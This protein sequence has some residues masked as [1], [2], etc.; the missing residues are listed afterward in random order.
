[1][2]PGLFDIDDC[3]MRLDKAGDPL[4]SLSK[5]IDWSGLAELMKTIK[6]E[7]E[8]NGN[9]GGRRPLDGLMMS[10]ILILQAYNNLSDENCEFLI[11]DRMT[12]KRFLGL[13]F[14]Q[15][16]P[17]A[18]AIWLWRERIKFSGLHEKI[19]AWFEKQLT[20]A[21]FIAN[22]GQIIDATFVPTHKPGGKHKKQ[23]KEEIALTPAQAS[24]I[25]PD[26]TFTKKGGR[27]YHGYKNHIQID[28]QYKLIRK[29]EVTTAS[30]HDSQEL[31]ALLDRDNTGKE[32]WADS[33]YRS[34]E[35]EEKLAE[36]GFISH[37]NER[38]YRNAPL[39]EGQKVANHKR[40]RVRARG[41]HPFAFMNNSMGGLL[42]HTMT[43]ARAK[44]KIV[45]KNLV[46]NMCRFAYLQKCKSQQFKLKMAA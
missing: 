31:G 28:K 19:F 4:L 12:Y 21:G 9:K 36:Q 16:A 24:Q 39:T 1:M 7:S 45:F 15:K 22:E 6:F 23:I 30:R 29:S 8:N 40:S 27:H 44:V 14:N 34:K 11:N 46:Y 32:I 25:D 33:A 13:K 20:Q 26:A 2:Q 10:K 41:E 17:D 35:A 3:Y 18:K 37:I 42:I 43:L 5:A 38:A